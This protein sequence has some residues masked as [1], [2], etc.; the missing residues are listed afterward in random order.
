LT[1]AVSK[2]IQ[3]LLT[4]TGKYH[5]PASTRQ[6]NGCRFAY[7]GTCACDNSDFLLTHVVSPEKSSSFFRAF[8]GWL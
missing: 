2:L 3:G 6:C 4:T 8:F 7:T 1:E 5:L